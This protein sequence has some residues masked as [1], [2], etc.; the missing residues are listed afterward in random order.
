M[1]QPKAALYGRHGDSKGW[2]A[3]ALCVEALPLQGSVDADHYLS[4]IIH[5]IFMGTKA[6]TC[7]GQRKVRLGGYCTLH[8]WKR[9]AKTTG[10]SSPLCFWASHH[11]LSEQYFPKYRNNVSKKILRENNFLFKRNK[12]QRQIP[13][14]FSLSF[15]TKIENR[16]FCCFPFYVL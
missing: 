13:F 5:C 7:K 1:A 10:F 9:K 12:C 6:W 4:T 15:W 16:F 2:L 3:D 11:T 8:G 14:K